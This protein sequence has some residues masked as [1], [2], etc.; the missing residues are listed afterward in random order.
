VAGRQQGTG[1]AI[2]PGDLRL[3]AA[4]FEL[5][6]VRQARFLPEGLISRNWQITADRGVFA[7]KQIRDAPLPQARRNLRVVV[8]LHA[9]GIPAF[10]PALTV[11]GDTVAEAGSHGYCLSWWIKGRH[12]HGTQLTSGQARHAGAVLG[13]VH[14]SLNQAGPRRDFQ[15]SRAA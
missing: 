10:E 5:G 6:S 15:T 8:A 9:A 11:T 1:S 12:L 13:R 7:L 2:P 4:A 14:E 3:V